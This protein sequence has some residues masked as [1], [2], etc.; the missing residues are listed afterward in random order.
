M[1][2]LFHSEQYNDDMRDILKK[3]YRYVPSS[4]SV[5]DRGNGAGDSTQVN[6]F[7]VLFGGDQLTT[8]RARTVKNVLSNSDSASSRLQ[9]LIP[10][11]EDWHAKMCLYKVGVQF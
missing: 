8:E 11:T 4:G 1:G 10:V 5:G 2:V 6:S 9:G 3:V 7:P